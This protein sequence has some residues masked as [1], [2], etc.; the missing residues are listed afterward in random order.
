MT[1]RRPIAAFLALSVAALSPRASAAAPPP[2]GHACTPPDDT[3]PWCDASQP[4]AARV[5][6]LVGAMTLAEKISLTYDGQPAIPRLGLSTLFNYNLEGLHGLGSHCM[7]AEGGA[8]GCPTIFPAP[9]AL[10]A[11]GVLV[12]IIA[13]SW[14]VIDLLAIGIVV[15]P[16]SD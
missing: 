15:F 3:F 6:A 8:T 7:P 16:S 13:A 2:H 10:G 9:P 11:A 1:P 12:S 5:A 4:V 14:S